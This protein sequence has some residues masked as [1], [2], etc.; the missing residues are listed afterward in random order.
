M[1]GPVGTMPVI[2]AP[3]EPMDSSS[4]RGD[5]GVISQSGLAIQVRQFTAG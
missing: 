2:L 4:N 5:T 3:M 1:L